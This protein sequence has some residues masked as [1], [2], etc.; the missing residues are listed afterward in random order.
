MFTSDLLHLARGPRAVPC[1]QDTEG[2]Y[3]QDYRQND[4]G[5]ARANAPTDETNKIVIRDMSRKTA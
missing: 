5:L 1:L 4:L 2:P 3:P